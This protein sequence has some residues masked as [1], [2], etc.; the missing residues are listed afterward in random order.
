ML[1]NLR[2]EIKSSLF[3]K[4]KLYSKQLRSKCVCVCVCVFGGWIVEI[5][6]CKFST[7]GELYCMQEPNRIVWA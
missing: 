5:G 7:F 1:I 3:F 6:P 4:E 2:T